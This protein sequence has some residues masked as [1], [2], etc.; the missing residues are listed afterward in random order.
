MIGITT[1][2]SCL[3]STH[4]G[5]KIDQFEPIVGH[6]SDG[7]DRKGG[8]DARVRTGA[9]GSAKNAVTDNQSHLA[10]RR[11]ANGHR[12]DDVT[13]DVNEPE[14]ARPQMEATSG[15]GFDSWN[16]QRRPVKVREYLK[17]VVCGCRNVRVTAANPS[18]CPSDRRPSVAVREPQQV[19]ATSAA[20]HRTFSAPLL[21]RLHSYFLYTESADSGHSNSVPTSRPQIIF[22]TK[23][24]MYDNV[25]AGRR[26][27]QTKK[28]NK[29]ERIFTTDNKMS[30]GDRRKRSPVHSSDDEPLDL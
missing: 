10:C 9:A 4:S 3:F 18:A 22:S 12:Y 14:A 20:T 28:R 17:N 2:S 11:A 5:I 16:R 23:N 21:R 24:N 29:L 19:E 8:A 15:A 27:S 1:L 7:G 30:S 26:S 25:M 13:C 6:K